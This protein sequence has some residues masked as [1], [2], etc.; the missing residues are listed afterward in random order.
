MTTSTKIDQIGR[1]L[2]EETRTDTVGLWAVLWQVKHEMPALTPDET[3]QA[4]LIVIRKALLEERVVAGNFVD[5]DDDNKAFV[6]WPSSAE[7]SIARIDR[8][9]T[10]LGREPNLGDVVWFVDPHLLPVTARKHPMGKGW[11]PKSA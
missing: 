7:D 5:E 3:K 11:K 2:V 9:W 8:E 1:V 4:T 6:V 10:A